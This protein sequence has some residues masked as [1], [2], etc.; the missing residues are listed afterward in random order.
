MKGAV[1]HLESIP[2]DFLQ[3]NVVAKAKAYDNLPL[4]Y[5]S[6]IL[7][8]TLQHA[9]IVATRDHYQD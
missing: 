6:N 4:A 7:I 5:T 3:K 1:P 9:A 8:H 2:D